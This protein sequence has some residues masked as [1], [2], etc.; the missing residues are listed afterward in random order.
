[1]K[2]T[3]NGALTVG[4]LDGANVEIREEVGA[5]NFFL[6]GL[7]ADEVA[8]TLAGGYRPYEIYNND[9][10]L[11]GVIDLIASGF[12]SDGD[13]GCYRPLV[14]HLIWHDNYLVLADYASYIAC[15]NEVGQCYR[16]V[17]RWT[18]MSILNAAR[19]GKFSSDR[20]IDEYRREIWQ[21]EPVP[22]TI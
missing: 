20:T 7:T 1:M 18:R 14:E 16:D 11:R 6:F 8:H 9:A 19:M 2:F 10:E 15:Q 21:A 4:T 5:E 3:M 13:A 12:F 22:I 17:R